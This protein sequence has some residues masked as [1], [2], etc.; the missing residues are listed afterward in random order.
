MRDIAAL[1][2][3]CRPGSALDFGGELNSRSWKGSAI[4]GNR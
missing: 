1:E 3:I 2:G 4:H